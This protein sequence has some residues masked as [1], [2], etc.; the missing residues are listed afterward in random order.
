MGDSQ[1]FSMVLTRVFSLLSLCIYVC[2][3]ICTGASRG[4]KRVSGFL[5]SELQVLVLGTEL[6]LTGRTSVLNP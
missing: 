2:L 5:E 6:R 4:Q 3:C 1:C